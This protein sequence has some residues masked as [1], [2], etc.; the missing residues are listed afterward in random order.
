MS[1]SRRRFIRIA[2]SSAVLVAAAGAVGYLSTRDPVAARV[3]PGHAA[4]RIPTR[5]VVP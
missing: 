3:H 4:A 2:G 5:F 1:F